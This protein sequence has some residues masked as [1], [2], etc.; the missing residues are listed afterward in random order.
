MVEMTATMSDR[1][2]PSELAFRRAV[3]VTSKPSPCA[4][5]MNLSNA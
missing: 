5:A 1:V 3:P 4:H 2:K